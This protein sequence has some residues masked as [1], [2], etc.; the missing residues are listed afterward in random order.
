MNVEVWIEFKCYWYIGVFNVFLELFNDIYFLVM[1]IGNMVVGSS[2]S[3]GDDIVGMV[4]LVWGW[5]GLGLGGVC[6][7]GFV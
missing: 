1:Y 4:R 3:V 7:V 2:K 6:L 5:I